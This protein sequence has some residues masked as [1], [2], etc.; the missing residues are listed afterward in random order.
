[1]IRGLNSPAQLLLAQRH[2]GVPPRGAARRN[3]RCGNRHRRQRYAAAENVAAS[4]ALTPNSS[5]DITRVRPG[6]RH[7]RRAGPAPPRRGTF[8]T[9]ARSAAAHP[10]A[11][12]ESGLT[13]HCHVSYGGRHSFSCYPLFCSRFGSVLAYAL[14][15]NELECCRCYSHRPLHKNDLRIA[16]VSAC[17]S[18]GQKWP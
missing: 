3:Y 11:G 13:A 16:P 1:M 17:P 4:V 15:N 2:H 18:W 8:S 6:A 7:Q 12:G 14:F 9:R 5:L 10:G